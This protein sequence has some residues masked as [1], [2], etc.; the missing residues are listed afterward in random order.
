MPQLLN[1]KV[2]PHFIKTMH[3]A[4]SMQLNYVNETSQAPVNDN[5]QLIN[6]VKYGRPSFRLKR[7]GG[8]GFPESDA[9]WFTKDETTGK[10]HLNCIIEVFR[11]EAD[12][13]PMLIK[14]S[15]VEMEYLAEGKKM[16]KTLKITQSPFIKQTNI[17]QD[18]HAETEISE[19]EIKGLIDALTE[20]NKAPKLSIKSE[21]WWQKPTA[22]TARPQP[23]QP[24]TQVAKP[25][26]S[27][28]TFNCM[29]LR[30]AGNKILDNGNRVLW[31]C[32]NVEEAKWGL[33][34]LKFYK[35][36]TEVC[37]GKNKQCQY[38]LS[39]G[40]IPVGP[41][42][43]W[44]DLLLFDKRQV[45]ISKQNNRWILG[46]DN[47]SM[48]NFDGDEASAKEALRAIRQYGADGIGYMK[49]PRPTFMY[50]KASRAERAFVS[51]QLK[52]S[53][54]LLKHAVRP[55]QL[56]AVVAATA[57][58]TATTSNKPQK[59]DLQHT[60][61]LHYQKDD[62]AVFGDIIE[63]YEVKEY[64]WRHE[65][66]IKGE[67]HTIY[68]RPTA[69]P[70][71]FYFLPQVFRIKV[72]E[73][74][75]EPK[76]SIAMVPGENPDIIEQYRI[77]INMQI[78]PYYNPKAKKDLYRTLDNISGGKIKYCKLSLGGFNSAAFG[79][80]GEY[81]GENAVFR[82]K[83]TEKIETIDPIN[84]FT[85]SVDCTLESFDFFK[86][87][88]VNG[89]NIGDIIFDLVEETEEGEN[90]T[91]S[92]PIPVELD[93]RKLGGLDVGVDIIQNEGENELFPKGV[94]L[95]N[96]NVFPISVKGAEM[97]LLSDVSGT[98]YEADYDIGNSLQT[99]PLVLP[100]NKGG[101]QEVLLNES[102][103]DDLSG[104]DRFWT[105]LI[106]EPYGIYLNND[107]ESIIE[108]VIDYATGD[109]Q[110]WE[111][112]VSCPLLE[113][114]DDLDPTMLEPYKLLDKIEVEV[115]NASG[116]TWGIVLTKNA[117]TSNIQMARSIS[118][119]LKTQ[120]I[121]DRKYQYRVRSHYI[122]NKTDWTDW[123]DPDSTAANFLDVQPQLLQN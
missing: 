18:I 121:D 30:I 49:R 55:V 97:T 21:L 75:G 104:E 12:V 69:R 10:I 44:E 5:P 72:N 79:L 65:S 102:E 23:A 89:F 71:T 118:D 110:I 78:V 53:T 59:L 123:T 122:L 6:G 105:Q 101:S 45:T 86:R 28:R 43:N 64:K 36:D 82:G 50:F 76:I 33:H 19:Q 31:N 106:C 66:I 62:S 120:Q 61:V 48:I 24:H 119:I 58:A 60:I 68:Y 25:V 113:R 22:A 100:E 67:M 95:Y 117:F 56:N 116:K 73:Y 90:V 32:K 3:F 115:K 112:K 39:R 2:Q 92:Q 96:A 16:V 83:V 84:G 11:E 35:F 13:Q 103:V 20:L 38:F 114:W 85:L 52:M 70:D 80:R 34:I 4:S 74:T 7:R 41:K 27:K 108:R 94:K 47:R 14:N 17:L 93:I 29:T 57:T 98:V 8:D 54:M 88:I 63:Q 9:F 40:R 81:A 1:L 99:W 107:P 77:I 109:P 46:Y 91:S 15:S 42:L 87:E 51:G 37:I 111:L 26:I